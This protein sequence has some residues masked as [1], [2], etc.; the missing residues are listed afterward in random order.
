MVRDEKCQFGGGPCW[1]HIRREAEIGQTL[2]R[3]GA[4]SRNRSTLAPFPHRFDPYQG[5]CSWLTRNRADT[6]SSAHSHQ[7]SGSNSQTCPTAFIISFWKHHILNSN[8]RFQQS[9]LRSSHKLAHCVAAH[10]LPVSESTASPHF[11]RG[12]SLCKRNRWVVAAWGHCDLDGVN[13]G[14]RFGVPVGFPL[15]EHCGCAC[16]HS[17]GLKLEG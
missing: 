5:Q 8:S 14:L 15:L 10:S 16:G 4:S 13:S 7:S 6:L 17:R 12:V 2:T 1:V 11:L 9:R 3:R